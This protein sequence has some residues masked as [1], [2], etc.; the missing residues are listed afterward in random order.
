ML[1]FPSSL[2]K[3][4]SWTGVGGKPGSTARK[5]KVVV[6]RTTTGDEKMG[7][8]SDGSDPSSVYWM[9][10]LRGEARTTLVLSR[11]VLAPVTTYGTGRTRGDSI[12]ETGVRPGPTPQPRS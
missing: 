8:D 11:K 9:R 4:A 3:V 5:R 10:A 2:R 12:R 1:R 7:E 6:R